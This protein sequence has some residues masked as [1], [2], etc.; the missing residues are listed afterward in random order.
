MQILR[1]TNDHTLHGL[2]EKLLADYVIHKG[3]SN[4]P[5][6]DEILCQLCNQTY[7]NESN[8]ASSRAWSL[9]SSVLSCFG[10][11]DQLFKYLLKYV[12]DC[13]PESMKSQLQYKILRSTL[14]EDQQSRS[15]PRCILEN[16]VDSRTGQGAGTS[17]AL[18]AF[19]PNGDSKLTC[20]DSWTSGEEFSTDLLKCK[21]IRQTFGWTVELIDE[22]SVHE[23]NGTDYVFDLIAATELAPDFPVCS[24][25]FLSS[26]HRS[27]P[28]KDLLIPSHH[29]GH[30]RNLLTQE[31]E[32]PHLYH[33]HHHRSQQA[34][35]HLMSKKESHGLMVN[36][37]NSRSIDDLRSKPISRE[38]LLNLHHQQLDQNQPQNLNMHPSHLLAHIE[39]GHLMNTSGPHNLTNSVMSLDRSSISLSKNS[40]LN[41]RYLHSSEV[42]H[43][44]L[45]GAGGHYLPGH[46]QNQSTGQQVAKHNKRYTSAASGAGKRVQDQANGQR[47]ASLLSKKSLSMQDLGLASSSALNERYFFARSDLVKSISVTSKAGHLEV[48]SSLKPADDSCFRLDPDEV[49]KNGKVFRSPIG[50]NVIR[51]SSRSSASSIS[52]DGSEG[53]GNPVDDSIPA[54][55]CNDS[56]MQMNPRYIKYP[57]KQAPTSSSRHSTK[58]YIDKSSDHQLPQSQLISSHDS[59]RLSDGDTYSIGPRS[60]AM[61]DTSEAPSLASHVRNVK[62]PS[63]MADLDQYLDDLFNPVLDGNLDELSDARSLAASIKGGKREHSLMKKC[64]NFVDKI[65]SSKFDSDTQIY[66]TSTL[67]CKYSDFDLFVTTNGICSKNEKQIARTKL[68]AEQVTCSIKGG[69][70]RPGPESASSA[71][72][73]NELSS[74]S[75][76][77]SSPASSTPSNRATNV[78]NSAFTNVAGMTVPI[79]DTSKVIQQQLVHQQ[80]IQRAFLASAVQQNLQIQQQLLQQNEALQKLLQTEAANSSSSGNSASESTTLPSLAVN[81]AGDSGISLTSSSLNTDSSTSPN[82][83]KG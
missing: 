36:S 16:V 19:L 6:R 76:S 25:F 65:Y 43:K 5:L 58:A 26:D 56:S 50:N 70:V 17:P 1:Y 72:S 80:M 47:T 75:S 82:S 41:S 29:L 28:R 2:K 61:S 11:S 64:E 81:S 14:Y 23:L 66:K 71:Q 60:S 55:S 9:M 39:S 59:R 46:K 54:S 3:L 63:H 51:P 53:V 68:T 57:G 32:H 37:N 7:R 49:K 13:A 42:K 45:N 62:I 73:K 35:S 18:E 34:V 69:G 67:R 21:S 74:S 27:N 44:Q 38:R 8:F 31:H 4:E 77:S 12:T 22:D 20:L 15:F 24:S 83:S 40:R 78:T 33:A 30:Q 48:G 79:V 10:P 52:T